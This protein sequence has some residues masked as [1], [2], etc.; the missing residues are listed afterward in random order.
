MHYT[1]HTLWLQ[2]LEYSREE[3]LGV[4]TTWPQAACSLPGP[5]SAFDWEG[6][7]P[8]NLPM[9]DL[10]IYEMHVRGFTWDRSSK[11]SSPGASLLTS[12]NLIA[13]GA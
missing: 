11:T 4:A 12:P 6:D 5:S 10:V 2:D 3:V 1:C 9:E 13:T 7:H 8:L